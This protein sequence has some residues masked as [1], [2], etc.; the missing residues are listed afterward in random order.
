V[1]NV[2]ERGPLVTVG[3]LRQPPEEKFIN[4]SVSGCGFLY[5]LLKPKK[6][7]PKTYEKRIKQQL[8]ENQKGMLHT[9]I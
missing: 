5:T 1:G 9:D 7:N 3:P 8:N 2:A 4:K 6:N